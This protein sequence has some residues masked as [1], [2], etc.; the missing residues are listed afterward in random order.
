[1]V[2]NNLAR[3]SDLDD[4]VAEMMKVVGLDVRYLRRY[5]HAFS[6]GQRQ[7]IS[8]ARALIMMPSFIVADEPTS[9]LDVSIQAQILNL[10]MDLQE[11]F[12]LTYLFI[13][14]NLSVVKHVSRR[15][16]IMYLGRLVEISDKTRIFESPLHPYTQA[17]MEAI[18]KPDPDQPS[19]LK[20]APGEIGNPANPPSGC[21]FHPRCAQ[22]MDVCRTTRPELINVG[23]GH[24]VACHLYTPAPSEA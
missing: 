14:H 19:G 21:A 11:Q 9:A 12:G 16:G 8:L 10:M 18:P 13:S 5:P 7:R 17:L 1:M 23:Q 22:C 3:G 20:S 6:G 24:Y 15:V 2:I 4:K